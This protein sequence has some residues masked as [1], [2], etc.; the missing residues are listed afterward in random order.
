MNLAATLGRVYGA[1]NWDLIHSS[2]SFSSKPAL[3]PLSNS[4][5]T[6][7]HKIRYQIRVTEELLIIIELLL[8]VHSNQKLFAL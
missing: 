1:Q 7:E 6:G 4:I 8:L 5:K 2:K 3:C